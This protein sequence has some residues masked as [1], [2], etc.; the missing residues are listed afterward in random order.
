MLK[1]IQL[2][3]TQ[4]GKTFGLEG[5][6]ARCDSC[7]EPLEIDKI[8][9]GQIDKSASDS[10]LR[11]YAEYLPFDEPD[12]LV[13][14][15][16]GFTPLTNSTKVAKELEVSNVFFKNEGLNPTWSFK[17]RGTAVCVQHALDLGYK[18]I[19]T[20]STGNM[21]ASVAAYGTHADLKAII[22]VKNS[23]ASEKLGQIAVYDPTLIKVDGDYGDLYFESLRIGE[24]EGVYFM[25]SDVPMRVEGS[26]TI[27]FEICEQL[28]FN[29]PDYVIV[30]TSAAGNLRGII[31]GFEE[32]HLSGLI[33]KMPTF[34]C[35]QASGCSPITNA[36]LQHDEKIT[37]V[38]KPE[39]VAHAIENPYPPSGNQALRKLRAHN[40]LCVAVTDDEI[41]SAQR[42]LARDGI[43][44][45]TASAVPLAVL[46][47]MKSD[48]SL[49]KDMTV[50]CVVSGSGLK[51]IGSTQPHDVEIAECRLDDLAAL[52]SGKR[53]KK[54]S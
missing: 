38:E 52:L 43:F 3:C 41:R 34:V 32:F 26:K 25:N 33:E 17:D 11:R 49:A 53:A 21:A 45:Q 23:I 37:R 16:E 29:V 40:G 22:L 44:A 35:A 4:C 10:I 48:G 20:V 19:G 24:R 6:I 1:K 7:N 54:D 14:L 30:P 9:G 31:K 51:T 2:S 12:D 36:F 15:G 18:R 8:V 47:R 42:R 13:T 28:D 5:F 50:V 39:T 27:S 46:K